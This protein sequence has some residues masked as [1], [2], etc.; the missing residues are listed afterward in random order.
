MCEQIGSGACASVY[1]AVYLPTLSVVAVKYFPIHDQGRRRQ[2][3]IHIPNYT[4]TQTRV[5]TI[6]PRQSIP[7]PPPPLTP[8]SLSL[9]PQLMQELRSFLPLNWVLLGE[10]LPLPLR[11]LAMGP[12]SPTAAGVLD[13]TAVA[14]VSSTY[15]IRNQHTHMNRK[16]GKTGPGCIHMLPCESRDE[17]APFHVLRDSLL[18]K[19][20]PSNVSF[21]GG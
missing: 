16:S 3:H 20:W 6:Y 2:V 1:R 5:D 17:C 15:C 4:N 7:P 18:I 10:P 13:V 14:S 11:A 8:P 12:G 21:A 19:R 9:P